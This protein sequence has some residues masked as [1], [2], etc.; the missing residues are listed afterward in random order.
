[1]KE[2]QRLHVNLD[3]KLQI[4]ECDVA[5]RVQLQDEGWFLMRVSECESHRTSTRSV[6]LEQ[7]WSTF[8]FGGGYGRYASRLLLSRIVGVRT[9]VSRFGLFS[10]ARV[11]HMRC[12]EPSVK[13]S[14]VCPSF[15]SA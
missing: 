14:T 8:D 5:A 3:G 1:M 2:T 12:S 6:I 11:L 9:V 15:V 13:F 7:R 4:V 10:G